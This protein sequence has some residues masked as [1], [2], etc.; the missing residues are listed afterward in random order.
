MAG[1]A[2]KDVNNVCIC[3]WLLIEIRGFSIVMLS[4]F[5]LLQDLVNLVGIELVDLSNCESLCEIHPSVLSLD[6]LSSLIL[7]GCMKLKSIKSERHL[8][9]LQKLSVD[10]CSNLKDLRNSG[11][12]TLH[13]S[14]GRL[15]N[16][17]GLSLK[18]LPDELCC[19]TSLMELKIS[20]CIAVNKQKLCVLFE[21]LL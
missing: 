8:R 13:S 7:D 3:L 16:L 5:E 14:I 21:G 1:D 10:G 17:E 11:V 6:S 9:S 4:P 20:N 19:L 12:K 2:G 18:N 15:I